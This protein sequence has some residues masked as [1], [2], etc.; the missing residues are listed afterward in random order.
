MR[1]RRGLFEKAYLV[2]GKWCRSS[3]GERRRRRRRGE[4]KKAEV[5]GA[6]VLLISMGGGGTTANRQ[7]RRR[8]AAG[9][10][11]GKQN[12]Q[13]RVRHPPMEQLPSSAITILVLRC[14]FLSLPRPN[15]WEAALQAEMV[16]SCWWGDAR[17]SLAY[18]GPRHLAPCRSCLDESL[19]PTI[20]ARSYFRDSV[21]P[22]AAVAKPSQLSTLPCVFFHVS[23][24]PRRGHV[25]PEMDVAGTPGLHFEA[26]GPF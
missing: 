2:Y 19:A 4:G 9:G 13:G 3:D 5:G 18:P 25:E 21:A 6:Q 26:V 20:A 16:S 8:H 10:G 11:V 7:G 1:G 15:G 23:P 14:P 17:G 24:E 22:D 12:G